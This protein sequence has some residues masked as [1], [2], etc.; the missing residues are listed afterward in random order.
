MKRDEITVMKAIAICYKPYLKPEEAMIYCNLGHTQLAKR[1]GEFG[2][3]KNTRGYYKREELDL[4][5]SGG[6]IKL[7]E[8]AAALPFSRRHCQ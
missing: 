5:M 4:M 8:K 2:I 6:E 1:L 3:Y 7:V